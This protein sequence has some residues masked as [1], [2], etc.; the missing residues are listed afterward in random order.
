MK[1]RCTAALS[2]NRQ[3]HIDNM[4][5]SRPHKKRSERNKE[6]RKDGGWLRD[7]GVQEHQTICSNKL[8][9]H[10]GICKEAIN[11]CHTPFF[12]ATCYCLADIQWPVTRYQH[13]TTVWVFKARSKKQWLTLYASGGGRW[14]KI[15]SCV[16]KHL[17]QI[18]SKKKK[19]KTGHV[20]QIQLNLWL[21]VSN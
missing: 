7:G 5:E 14:L 18:R 16:Y 15:V 8:S 3:S 10:A 1:F 4:T 11:Y 21:G 17:V 12:P 13:K 2:G 19:L 9:K 20:P 6:I